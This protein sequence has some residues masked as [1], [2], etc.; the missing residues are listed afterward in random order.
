MAEGAYRALRGLACEADGAG[1]INR[2]SAIERFLASIER[3]TVEFIDELNARADEFESAY[4]EARRIRSLDPRIDALK[5]ID[6]IDGQIEAGERRREETLLSLDAATDKEGW[7]GYAYL[8]TARAVIAGRLPPEF[9]SSRLT[10]QWPRLAWDTNIDTVRERNLLPTH[11]IDTTIERYRAVKGGRGHI[12]HIQQLEAMNTS[13][14]QALT[15]AYGY[16]VDAGW[17]AKMDKFLKTGSEAQGVGVG[18]VSVACRSEDIV[19]GAQTSLQPV[20]VESAVPW[21]PI[22]EGAGELCSGALS[23]AQGPLTPRPQIRFGE[24]EVVRFDATQPVSRLGA[25]G[26]RIAVGPTGGWQAGET[27]GFGRL[28][29]ISVELPFSRREQIVHR[30]MAGEWLSAAR[31]AE[32]SGRYNQVLSAAAIA[33]PAARAPSAAALF[34]DLRRLFDAAGDSFGAAASLD[35]D[36]NVIE[37]MLRLLDAS[38]HTA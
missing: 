28:A 3:L 22:E 20:R 11:A 17:L 13:I 4:V 25:G 19:G 6:W 14:D 9:D 1:D 21:D 32:L 36:W 29:S 16:R 12:Q 8:A 38:S 30:L 27:P 15:N 18:S 7:Q 24:D 34:E 31:R 37:T 35:I 33:S 2:A 26:G 23:P 10:R 5:V